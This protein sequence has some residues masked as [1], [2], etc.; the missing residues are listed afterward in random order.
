MGDTTPRPFA[1]IHGDGEKSSWTEVVEDH[2]ADY[3]CKT[4]GELFADFAYQL[5]N[6]EYADLMHRL[7]DCAQAYGAVPLPEEVP[8]AR[9]R[10]GSVPATSPTPSLWPCAAA[11]SKRNHP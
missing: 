9:P 2:T 5:R 10:G 1:V 11:C 7:N 8:A 3:T 4:F 6:G